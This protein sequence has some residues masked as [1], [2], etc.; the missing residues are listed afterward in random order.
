[1][2]MLPSHSY[3]SAHTPLTVLMSGAQIWLQKTASVAAV[4]VV[5]P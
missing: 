5:I 3:P 1:M 4:T 2:F